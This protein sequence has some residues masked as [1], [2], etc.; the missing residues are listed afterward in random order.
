MKKLTIAALLA[1][2]VLAAAQPAMAADFAEAR[3]QRAGAFAGLRLRMPLDGPQRRHVRAGFALAPT[4]G[5]REM[6]GET[7]TRIGEGL[8]FGY[9][10][11]RPLSFSI[12]GQDLDRRRFGAAQDDEGNDTLPRIGLAVLVVGALVGLTYWGFSEMLDCDDGD[13]CS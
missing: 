5:I 2:Q 6:N 10:T 3:E 11:N 7:R 9:R 4:L 8:E 12:A 13:D 1:G